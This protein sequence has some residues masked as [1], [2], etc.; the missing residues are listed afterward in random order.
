MSAKFCPDCR[1]WLDSFAS[2]ADH[3][4]DNHP[5]LDEDEDEIEG[6]SYDIPEVPTPAYESG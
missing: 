6:L 4:A 5:E 3:V 2:L 1:I